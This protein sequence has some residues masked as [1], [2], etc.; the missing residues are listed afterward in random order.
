[1]AKRL[2]LTLCL[3]IAL[4][5]LAGGTGRYAATAAD[6]SVASLMRR[7]ARAD[8]VGLA[9]DA[10]GDYPILHPDKVNAEAKLAYVSNFRDAFTR[11]NGV[12]HELKPDQPGLFLCVYAVPSGPKEYAVREVGQPDCDTPLTP[13]DLR[14]EIES[15][16]DFRS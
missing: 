10:V 13:R 2:A 14:R 12:L 15:R 8:N 9:W 16:S 11:L 6:K 1:M 3:A 7:W 5:V 4:P